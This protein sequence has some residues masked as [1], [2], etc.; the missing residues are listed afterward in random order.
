VK[1]VRDCYRDTTRYEYSA[2]KLSL[3]CQR[4][5]IVDECLHGYC[6]VIYDITLRLSLRLVRLNVHDVGR[7][8]GFEDCLL[9]TD[10]MIQYF[11][12]EEQKQ[13]RDLCTDSHALHEKKSYTKTKSTQNF[14]VVSR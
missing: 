11:F 14:H 7:E 8:D 13:V 6:N 12:R 4:L 9:K 10:G 1:I 3:L 2:L 5:T